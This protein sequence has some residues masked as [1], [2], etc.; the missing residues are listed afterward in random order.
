MRWR[1]IRAI[2]LGCAAFLLAFGAVL[3]VGAHQRAALSAPVTVPSQLTDHP[4]PGWV[5]TGTQ[6]QTI[7]LSSFSGGPLLIN[8]WAT[9]CHPCKQELPL[10]QRYAAHARSARVV[11]I[12]ELEGI[13]LVAPFV[14]DAGISYPIALDKDGSVGRSYGVAG[15]PTTIAIDRHGIVRAV[16]LGQLTENDLITLAR[17]ATSS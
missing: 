17:L 6:G 8:F 2:L 5:L 15:L 9:W 4:A 1:V 12:D 16:H 11:G 10:L 13:S 3:V 7:T 14:H